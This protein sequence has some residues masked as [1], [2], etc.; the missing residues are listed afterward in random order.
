VA[1][2]IIIGLGGMLVLSGCTQLSSLPN[3][4]RYQYIN[5]VKDELDYAATGQII[6]EQYDSGDGVF[7][8]SFFYVEVEG[9]AT[10]DRLTE[11]SKE[12]ATRQCNLLADIQTKCDVGQVSILISRDSIEDTSITLK[13]T[14]ASNGRD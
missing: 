13:I 7:S 10:F 1:S 14:D 8:P 5:Q 12:L 4:E 3:E 2:A 11:T 6:K 9:P